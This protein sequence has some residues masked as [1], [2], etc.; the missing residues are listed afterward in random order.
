M[1]QPVSEKKSRL[2]LP[3]VRITSRIEAKHRHDAKLFSCLQF[4]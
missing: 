3:D 4:G 2:R 1:R